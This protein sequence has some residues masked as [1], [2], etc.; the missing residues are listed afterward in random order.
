M[1]TI[2]RVILGLML[3]GGFSSISAEEIVVT[4]E[5]S[6]CKSD[7]KNIF[8]CA[9]EEKVVSLC[10]VLTKQKQK[11][12]LI[13]RFGKENSIPELEY[14]SKAGEDI[15]KYFQYAYSVYPKGSMFEVEF[16]KSKYTYTIAQE[17]H[18]YIAPNVAG[19]LVEKA[20]RK[21]VELMCNN[22]D[23]RSNLYDLSLK[24]NFEFGEHGIRRIFQTAD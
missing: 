21:I 6:L 14:S 12:I 10:A 7:E 1:Q 20:G 3:I 19:V 2:K 17:S 4:K 8:S 15:N 9:A 22:P 16:K 5:P 11:N 13:Y 23:I 24:E 18:A